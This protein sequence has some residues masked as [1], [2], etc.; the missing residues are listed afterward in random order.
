[1]YEYAEFDHNLHVTFTSNNACIFALLQ[2]TKLAKEWA[3]QLAK[4]DKMSH[5]K[6]NSDGENIYCKV[7]NNDIYFTVYPKLTFSC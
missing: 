2:L 3:K 6:D 1:M 5:R 7:R 4:D